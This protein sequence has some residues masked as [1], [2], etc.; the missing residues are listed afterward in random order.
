MAD[1]CLTACIQDY[2]QSSHTARG[3]ICLQQLVWENKKKKEKST[4]LSVV[5]A[6]VAPSTNRGQVSMPTVFD[7]AK[8]TSVLVNNHN[9]I[10]AAC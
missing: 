7:E 1:E 3:S 9:K 4:P 8:E 5:T 2:L 6:C 10:T